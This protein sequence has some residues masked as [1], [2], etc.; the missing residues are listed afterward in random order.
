MHVQ[1]GQITPH[2]V[3]QIFS[4]YGLFPCF[5]QLNAALLHNARNCVRGI[6]RT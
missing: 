6:R 2:S 5:S 3:Q 1:L 4:K